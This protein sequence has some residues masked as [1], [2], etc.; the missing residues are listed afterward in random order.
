[1]HSDAQNTTDVNSN[2]KNYHNGFKKKL[3]MV[4]KWLFWHQVKQLCFQSAPKKQFSYFQKRAKNDLFVFIF[5]SNILD[6]LVFFSL[7]LILYTMF[8]VLLFIC[9]SID[10]NSCHICVRVY[11]YA[12]GPSPYAYTFLDKYVYI[13]SKYFGRTYGIID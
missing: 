11:M 13:Y 2:Q 9:S 12:F 6:A 5:L 4:K 1:M 3:T 7:I 8:S 10:L